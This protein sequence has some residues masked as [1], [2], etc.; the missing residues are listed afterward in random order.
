MGGREGGE[1][2]EGGEGREG[3]CISIIHRAALNFVA[4][5]I[6]QAA[7]EFFTAQL[8]PTLWCI[9]SQQLVYIGNYK[10]KRRSSF[11]F[12]NANG[13][14]LFISWMTLLYLPYD[15]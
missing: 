7:V 12:R 3:G 5:K 1:G 6:C 14:F 2:G 9:F 15:H 13:Y 8:Y 4:L 10:L 11:A